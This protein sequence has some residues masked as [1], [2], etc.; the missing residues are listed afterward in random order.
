M[1]IKQKESKLRTKYYNHLNLL[2]FDKN[3]EELG[4]LIQQHNIL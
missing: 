1:R 3:V 2:E 4:N